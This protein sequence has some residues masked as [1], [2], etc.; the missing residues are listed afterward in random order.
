[1]LMAPSTWPESYGS[2]SGEALSAG[3]WVVASEI[4][5]MADPILHGQIGH[6]VPASDA[7]A[8]AAVLEQLAAHHQYSHP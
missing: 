1:V 4:G 2:V 5:A 8:L 6:R 3:L 7:T